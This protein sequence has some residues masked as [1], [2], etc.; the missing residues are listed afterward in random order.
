MEKLK[1][2]TVSELE[3]VYLLTQHNTEDGMGWSDSIHGV[4]VNK[5]EAIKWTKQVKEP[6]FEER[7]YSEIKV[8]KEKMVIA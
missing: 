3:R 8:L 6:N 7:T 2:Q 4:T 1:E 5:Q